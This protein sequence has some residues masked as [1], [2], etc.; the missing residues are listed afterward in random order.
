MNVNDVPEHILA[1]IKTNFESDPRVQKLRVQQGMLQR[2]RKYKEAL[3]LGRDID[4]LYNHA[5]Y[6]FMKACETEA[7]NISIDDIG[8]SADDKIE[9]LTRNV[10]LYMAMDMID[11]AIMEIDEI[12]HRTD[13]TLSFEMFNEVRKMSVLTK[14]KLGFLRTNTNYTK[15]IAWGDVCDNMYNMLLSKARSL[16]RKKSNSDWGKKEY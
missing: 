10:A 11:S 16:M 2:Q 9:V 5:V 15:D 13:K 7:K 3:A 6:E 8:L 14:E 12:L 4:K 1:L